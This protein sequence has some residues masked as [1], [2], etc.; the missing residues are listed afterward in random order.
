MKFTRNRSQKDT[1]MEFLYSNS[2]IILFKLN[3]N[4]GKKLIIKT[5]NTSTNKH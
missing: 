4:N 3:P 2:G 5:E 1:L